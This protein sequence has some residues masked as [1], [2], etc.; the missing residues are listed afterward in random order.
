[1]ILKPALIFRFR[2]Y[3]KAIFVFYFV[4]VIVYAL[5]IATASNFGLVLTDS[6]DSQT[7]TTTI[8][9]IEMASIIFLFVMG[10]NSFTEPFKM[11]L[12]N[13]VSRKT[14]FASFAVIALCLGVGMGL[15]NSLISLLLSGVE[16]YS[17]LF[18]EIYGN[19]YLGSSGNIA[20]YFA[21]F[22]WNS[23]IY[24]SVLFLGF[25]IATLYYRMSKGLKYTV[26]IGLPAFFIVLLPILDATL[27]GGSIFKGIS[28]FL[29]Y[30]FGISNGFNPYYAIIGFLVL[31]TVLCAIS[32]LLVKKAVIK[33]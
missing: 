14:I 11:F 10:L 30:I 32:Y 23:A 12:Q 15:I 7:V 28:S 6:S 27:T 13:S 17:T 31:S 25:L 9:G 3:K 5:F 4:I 29:L 1:M 18:F 24:I 33:E 16:K 22:L 26:S 19:R 2:D 20:L 21:E 8:S